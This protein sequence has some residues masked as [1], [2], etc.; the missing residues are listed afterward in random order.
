MTPLPQGELFDRAAAEYARYRP[1]IPGEAVRL[2]A[3][4]LADVP[5][6]TVVDLGSG[7][8]Q[9]P[10]ALLPAAP[11]IAHLDLVDV[12]WPMLRQAV[13]VLQ[14]V[15]GQT[16]VSVFIGQA[17]TFVPSQ[18]GRGPDLITCCRAYHPV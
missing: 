11:H 10:L 1:G 7:T 6:P 18:P 16:A 3:G 15:R 13:T 9:V 4:T 8:G 17:D 5:E 2:L 12:S 14:P